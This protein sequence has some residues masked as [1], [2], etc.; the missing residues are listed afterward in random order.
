MYYRRYSFIMKNFAHRFDLIEFPSNLQQ[1]IILGYPIEN[2]LD[3]F[4]KK[5]RKMPSE[6][7]TVAKCMLF[8]EDSIC[9]HLSNFIVHKRVINYT[10]YMMILMLNLHINNAFIKTHLRLWWHKCS[11]SLLTS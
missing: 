1:I 10:K 11:T 7:S 5:L 6:P 8:R 9:K 4:M 3:S 2:L